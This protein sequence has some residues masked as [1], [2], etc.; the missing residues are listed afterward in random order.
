MSTDLHARAIITAVDGVS[1]PLGAMAGKFKGFTA[2]VAAAGAA[3][4]STGRALTGGFTLP[5]AFAIHKGMEFDD[6]MG[7]LAKV[8]MGT[9]EQLD[10]TERQIMSF[11]QT[12]PLSQTELAK[13]FTSANQANVPLAEQA[14]FVELASKFMVAFDTTADEAATTLAKL[15]TALGYSNAELEYLSDTMNVVANNSSATEKELLAVYQD[16]ASLSNVLGGKKAVM[17]LSALGGAMAAMNVPL[18]KIGTGIRNLYVDLAGGEGAEKRV[19]EGLAKLGMTAK[20]VA[21]SLTQDTMGTLSTIFDKIAALPKEEQISVL[22]QL[23]SKRAID[24]FAPLLGNLE[25]FARLLA[26]LSDRAKVA[27]STNLEYILKIERL[28]PQLQLLENAFLGVAIAFTERWTPALVAGMNAVT[29]F[30][31]RLQ[32]MGPVAN[33]AFDAF[34]ALAIAGPGL[35]LA[36]LALKGVAGGMAAIATAATFGGGV[37]LAGL[38]ALAGAGLLIYRNWQDVA[39]AWERLSGAASSLGSSLKDLA[40]TITGLD[41]GGNSLIPEWANETAA[42]QA[43]TDV[44]NAL[45]SALERLQRVAAAFRERGFT[46]G[47]KQWGKETLG[48]W[49]DVGSYFKPS[50]SVV[51]GSPIDRMFAWE[52]KQMR[53]GGSVIPDAGPSVS[54]G[55]SVPVVPR[56]PQMSPLPQSFLEKP[57]PMSPLIRDIGGGAPIDVTGKVTADVTGKV[58]LEGRA[59]VNVTVRAIGV[60]VTGMNASSSGHIRADVGT[61]MS[62]SAVKP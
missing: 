30:V 53:P 33:A 55:P 3:I 35:W 12:I 1:G 42:I 49:G 11:A 38:A 44:M 6:A 14:G 23:A 26:L 34:G 21:K 22:N 48:F 54:S 37:P 29:D 36:G 61:S 25:E 19:H 4:A 60:Q 2:G 31:N 62:D 28:R 46:G 17:G 41:L 18:D 7:D 51:P 13:L 39:P 9:R 15:K 16:V 24:A 57:A 52:P 45:A 40:G 47:L 59:D 10:A 5:A 58:G 50:A 32:E 27:G 8:F 20:D 43:V 56:P